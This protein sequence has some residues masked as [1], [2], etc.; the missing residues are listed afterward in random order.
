MR[1]AVLVSGRVV[2]AQGGAGLIRN[3]TRLKEKFPG[4]DFYYGAWQSYKSEFDSVFPNEICEYFEEPVMPYHPYEIRNK[5]HINKQFRDTAKWALKEERKEW[6]SHHTKQILI[7]SWLL[8]KIIKKYDIVIRTRFDAFI[9]RSADFTS[10]ITDTFENNRANCFATT[11][12]QLFA[13]LYEQ[14]KPKSN[15]DEWHWFW[16]QLIIHPPSFITKQVVDILHETKTLHPAEFGWA[17]VL[18]YPYGLNHRAHKG[19]VNHDRNILDVFL[20]EKDK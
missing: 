1:V 15:K 3:N 12:K 17:Q 6:T 8:D 9:H 7:H 4:A 14:K 10:Y 5:Y 19:W 18:S 16:D 11:R 20:K 13:I 2:S